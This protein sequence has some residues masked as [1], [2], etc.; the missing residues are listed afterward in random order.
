MEVR[1]IALLTQEEQNHFEETMAELAADRYYEYNPVSS[2]LYKRSYS[3]V[4]PLSTL[5]GTP[6]H[7]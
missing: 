2:Q 5:L 7:L 1:R 4:H 6:V 3:N